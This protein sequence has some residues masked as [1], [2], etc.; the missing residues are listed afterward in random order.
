MN[1]RTHE[2]FAMMLWKETLASPDL[3][4]IWQSELG[5]KMRGERTDLKIFRPVRI[6]GG[7][8]MAKQIIIKVTYAHS[9]ARLGTEISRYVCLRVNLKK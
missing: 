8:I 6:V 7:F 3:H 2:V 1:E 5:L 9:Q 4:R